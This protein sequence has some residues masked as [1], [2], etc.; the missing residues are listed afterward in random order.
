MSTYRNLL[1]TIAGVK[2][3]NSHCMAC[4][5][6]RVDHVFLRGDEKWVAELWVSLKTEF[7]F[8]KKNFIIFK[9]DLKLGFHILE[10]RHSSFKI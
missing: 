2:F 6:F 9:P 5:S 10:T 4:A 8:L 3:K 1:Q 7:Y